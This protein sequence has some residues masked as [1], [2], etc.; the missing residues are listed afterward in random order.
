MECRIIQPTVP[1]HHNNTCRVCGVSHPKK[2]FRKIWK[3]RNERLPMK[4]MCKHCQQ[5]W[6]NS[7]TLQ[8]PPANFIVILD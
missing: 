4:V 8:V 3:L 2:F 1:I 5:I 7:K 6:A